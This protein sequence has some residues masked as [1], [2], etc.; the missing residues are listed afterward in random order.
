MKTDEMKTDKG[1]KIKSGNLEKCPE[2]K[3]AEIGLTRLHTFQKYIIIE[4]KLCDYTNKDLMCLYWA[5]PC[6]VEIQREFGL[7]G[8]AVL[9]DIKITNRDHCNLVERAAISGTFKIRVVPVP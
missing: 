4:K 5:R 2:F 8:H 9:S 3:S 7:K 6:N 1:I